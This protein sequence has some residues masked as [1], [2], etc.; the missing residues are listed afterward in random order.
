V[1]IQT[2]KNSIECWVKKLGGVCCV[3]LSFLCT[4]FT[5]G[6]GYSLIADHNSSTDPM[7]PRFLFAAGIST[8][9]GIVLMTCAMALFFPKLTKT[10]LYLRSVLAYLFTGPVMIVGVIL[11]VLVATVLN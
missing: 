7:N 2:S 11:L 5:I 8:L 4:V 6:T 1:E 9:V 10:D 3:V